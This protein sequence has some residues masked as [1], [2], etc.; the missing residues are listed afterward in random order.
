MNLTNRVT[1][2]S[3][4]RALAVL[5]SLTVVLLFTSTAAQAALF[6]W[7]SVPGYNGTAAKV[8]MTMFSTT[9]S[10]GRAAGEI[11]VNPSEG[12]GC[13]YVQGAPVA[14]AAV[15]GGWKRITANACSG[16]W[17]SYYWSDSFFLAYSGFKFRV[18]R[19]VTGPDPCG[20]TVTVYP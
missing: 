10:G 13:E 2:S 6:T 4:I 12:S 7:Y 14:R 15:D 5:A 18:C 9:S 17:R 20:S 8:K 11:Q 3:R 16:G 19:D 1:T